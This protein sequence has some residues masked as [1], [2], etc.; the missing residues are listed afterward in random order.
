MSIWKLHFS[1][2][3]NCKSIVGD[4]QQTR[5]P[6]KYV[7]ICDNTQ[8]VYSIWISLVKCYIIV[9]PITPNISD[10][11][12]HHG[13]IIFVYIYKHSYNHFSM[14]ADITEWLCIGK[15]QIIDQLTSCDSIAFCKTTYLAITETMRT[16]LLMGVRTFFPLKEISL[17]QSSVIK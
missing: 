11:K 16:S 5:L 2:L 12:V 14:T 8:W 4:C 10:L 9:W 6:R 13:Y 7:E 1:N 3:H 15:V 17:K